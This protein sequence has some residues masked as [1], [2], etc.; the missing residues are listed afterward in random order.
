M[1]QATRDD[2]HETPGVRDRCS[3]CRD[4]AEARTPSCGSSRSRVT[5]LPTMRTVS[6]IALLIPTLVLAR[7][8]ARAR[9]ANGRQAPNFKLRSKPSRHVPIPPQGFLHAEQP[10]ALLARHPAQLEQRSAARRRRHVVVRWRLRLRRLGARLP[11]R[12]LRPAR[13]PA[14]GG[15]HTACARGGPPP[16]GLDCDRPAPPRNAARAASGLPAAPRSAGPPSLSTPR[17]PLLCNN[18]PRLTLAAARL[19]ATHCATRPRLR[20]V[21][22]GRVSARANVG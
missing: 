11:L 6:F 7:L 17:V 19:P 2:P 13:L 1:W 16:P 22:R 5:T 4:R 10:P 14:R 18:P 8:V 3:A 20:G 15:R 9:A 21:R 12:R